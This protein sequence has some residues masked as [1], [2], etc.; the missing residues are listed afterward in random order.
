MVNCNEDWDRYLSREETLKRLEGH[1]MLEGLFGDPT[2]DIGTA[3][4]LAGRYPIRFCSGLSRSN[5]KAYLPE[6]HWI[7]QP[8]YA[9]CDWVDRWTIQA[10][11]CHC[12][13]NCVES[14]ILGANVL[15]PKTFRES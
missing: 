9:C 15:I 14:G 12:L 11:V 2:V 5:V 7:A 4:S 8:P 10:A 6:S 1:G 3:M 13:L